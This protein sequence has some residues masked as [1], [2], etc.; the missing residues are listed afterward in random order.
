MNRLADKLVAYLCAS[1]TIQDSTCSGACISL[2]V[3]GSSR[4]CFVAASCCFVIPQ[5]SCRSVVSVKAGPER[6]GRLW[7]VA[8][9]A[10]RDPEPGTSDRGGDLTAA[11][12]PV[13]LPRMCTSIRAMLRA[14]RAWHGLASLLAWLSYRHSWSRSSQADAGQIGCTLPHCG[15]KT[16]VPGR[17]VMVNEGLRSLCPCL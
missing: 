5:F 17:V 3:A 13:A 11:P 7:G 12:L 4:Q 16:A 15:N 9:S 1:Q 2:G 10:G 6:H 14:A 8:A